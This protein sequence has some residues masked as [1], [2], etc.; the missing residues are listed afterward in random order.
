MFPHISEPPEVLFLSL[1]YLLTPISHPLTWL[2]PPDSSLPTCYFWN[3]FYK[4]CSFSW[5]PV[6]HTYNPSKRSGG[7][8][9][10]NQPREIGHETISKKPFTK[11]GWWS[12]S[13]YRP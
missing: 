10:S 6:A 9:F 2:I 7:S 11:K 8:W 4:I 12:G 1:K 13:R 3:T 5:A